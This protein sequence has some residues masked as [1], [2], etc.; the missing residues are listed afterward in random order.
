MV[1]SW[2]SGPLEP[3]F[4]ACVLVF[5][6]SPLLE[7]GVYTLS[8]IGGMWVSGCPCVVL[9]VLPFNLKVVLL[10]EIMHSSHVAV[11][12]TIKN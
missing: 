12:E 4:R 1:R 7:F 3:P 8:A 9:L 2:G 10:N 6:L 11:R 5:W